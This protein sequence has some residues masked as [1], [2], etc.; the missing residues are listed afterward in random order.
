MFYEPTL[1]KTVPVPGRGPKIR[2]EYRVDPSS[3]DTPEKLAA[4]FAI[5][6]AVY[7]TLQHHFR[8]HFWDVE[9]V[10]GV[11]KIGIKA[12]LGK[13]TYN[14]PARDLTHWRVIEAGG[15]ILERFNIP[16]STID[17]PAFVAARKNRVRSGQK[18]PA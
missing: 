17:V 14:F 3:G 6:D 15:H 18:P 12:L 10:G 4:E 11:I 13:W 9:L 5:G 16:R 8:G 1:L 2:A 7:K